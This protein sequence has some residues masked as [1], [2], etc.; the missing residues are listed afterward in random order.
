MQAISTDMM[1]SVALKEAKYIVK[2]NRKEFEK[3]VLKKNSKDAQPLEKKPTV[4]ENIGEAQQQESQDNH[5][6][7]TYYDASLV[8]RKP[9]LEDVKESDALYSQPNFKG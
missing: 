4:V 6:Y 3:S 2:Q 8:D 7:Q 1:R 9:Y 5:K